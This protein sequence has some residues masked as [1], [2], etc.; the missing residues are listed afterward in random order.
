MVYMLQDQVNKLNK[1]LVSGPDRGNHL[2]S[3]VDVWLL[4]K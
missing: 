3:P 1:H 4:S 2:P